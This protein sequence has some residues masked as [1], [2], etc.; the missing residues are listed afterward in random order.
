MSW[1]SNRVRGHVARVEGGTVR[2]QGHGGSGQESRNKNAAR[3]VLGGG[4]GGW[5]G[6]GAGSIMSRTWS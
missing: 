5:A 4:A 6:K 1:G 3:G 2:V